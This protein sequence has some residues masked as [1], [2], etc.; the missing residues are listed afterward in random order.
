MDLRLSAIHLYPVKGIRGVSVDSAEAEPAGLRNDRRWIIVDEEGNFLSQRSLPRMA[1]VTGSFDGLKLELSAPGRDPMSVNLPDGKRRLQVTVWRDTVAAAAGD[2]ATDEWLSSFLGHSCRLAYM[3]D[4]CTRPISSSQG[5]AGETVSF[6]DGYPLLMISRAS[7][8]DLNSRLE[9]PLPMDRFRPNL[10]ID[11][12]PAF[13]EDRWR[14]IGIGKAVFRFAGL[15]PRCSVTTVDQQSGLRE[16]EEPLRTL[17]TYRNTE[18]GVVFGVNLIPESPGTI[19][20]G[21]EITIL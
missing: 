1:L 2:P 11:G 21:D 8:E 18:D 6:A 13:E 20:T 4:S 12:C 7:L 5:Q 9:A 3:D 17:V 14:R 19:S 15:C 10:V 16:S